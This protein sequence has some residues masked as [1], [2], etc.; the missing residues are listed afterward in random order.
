MLPSTLGT[1]D[2]WYDGLTVLVVNDDD[3]DGVGY[4][5]VEL[6]IMMTPPSTVGTRDD[7]V[8]GLLVPVQVGFTVM[9]LIVLVAVGIDDI[10]FETLLVKLEGVGDGDW[11]SDGDGDG[12]CDGKTDADDGNDEGDTDDGDDEVRMDGY[13]DGILV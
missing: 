11:D 4:D 12:S 13:V 9:S 7:W 3:D 6:V 10:G 8:D 5:D 1:R 2:D